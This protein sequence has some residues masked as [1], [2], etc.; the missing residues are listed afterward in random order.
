[1]NKLLTIILL[2]FPAVKLFAQDLEIPEIISAG[3]DTLT[4]KPLITWTM[5]NPDEVDGYIIKRLITDGDGVISG[6]YNNIAII[7]DN[8]VFSYVDLS[9]S[10][11][12]EAKAEK[13]KEYYR[14]SS[15]KVN[16]DGQT[17]YSLMSD[18]AY[19]MTLNGEFDYCTN[20][21]SF[22]FSAYCC[23]DKIDCYCLHSGFP[24]SQKLLV[25]KDTVCDYSF[26]D[27]SPSRSFAIETVLK[28]GA[29][30]FSPVI[31][32]EAQE[33]KKPET[34]N[35]ENITVNESE[36]L[37]LR[38]KISAESST[39]RLLLSRRD[40]KNGNAEAYDL[41]FQNEN[42]IFYDTTADVSRLY[43]YRLYALNNCGV[44]IGI[45]DSVANTVLKVRKSETGNENILEWN[46][47]LNWYGKIDKTEIYRSIDSSKLEYDNFVTAYYSEYNESLSNIIADKK[48][49]EGKFCYQVKIFQK[50]LSNGTMTT[51]SNTACI[52]RETVIFI[53][54]ALNP[55]SS[56][57][58][59][60]EFKPKADFLR[61]Y[62]MTIYT[63]RGENIFE[64]TD[65]SKGW[66]GYN[67]SGKLC[68][69]DTYVYII[70]Y[71]TSAGKTETKK[72]YVNLVY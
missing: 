7:E 71:K 48:L 44:A 12:T 63:K 70:T 58:E 31:F 57:S 65:V 72:G 69:R 23:P 55:K 52:N 4:G 38:I 59:N 25:T 16:Q 62:K 60:W 1:M 15:F 42:I 28:N 41:D 46:T 33:S 27:F 34:L 2:L 67:K 11:N 18:E 45:S 19:T 21:F 14:I 8:K 40:L 56:N 3:V 32:V 61:D 20:T 53:P 9:N 6:T 13:R 30:F 17:I 54:N 39:E 43:A 36:N 51:I 22:R 37:E 26:R 24:A 10:Y 68:Q 50:T 64:T 29:S 47:P 49:Y 35:I 66:D 5:Q